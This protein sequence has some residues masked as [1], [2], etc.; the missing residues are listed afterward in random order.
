MNYDLFSVTLNVVAKVRV[1]QKCNSE[2]IYAV[3]VVSLEVKIPGLL[4]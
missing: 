4:S 3:C 1:R 2:K